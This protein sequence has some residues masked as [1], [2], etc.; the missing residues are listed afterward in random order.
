RTFLTPS[1]LAAA[2]ATGRHP[3]PATSTWTSAPS[4]LAAVSAL[5]VASLRVLLSCSARRS[6]VISTARCVFRPRQ[7]T[8]SN[9]SHLILELVD[10]LA[11][12]LHLDAGLA[13]R[14]LSGLEHFEPRRGIDAVGIRRLLID[15]LL[16][17]LHDVREA[18]IAR[19]V[20]TQVGGHDRRSLQLDRLQA[21]VD[22]ASDHNAVALDHQLR[23]ERALR[24]TG[25]GRQHL[26]G[27]VAVVVDRLL[28]ENDQTR[29]L[30]LDN[31]LEDLGYG[32]RF[33][34]LVGLHQYAAVGTHGEPGANGFGGLRRA[35]RHANDLGGLALFL[36][37]ERLFDRDLV[38]RIHRHLDVREFDA[39]AVALDA[40][41]DVVVDDP[42][43]GHQNFHAVRS[44]DDKRTPPRRLAVARRN[45]A[46]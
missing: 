33:G 12:G 16:L 4:A 19:L 21:A 14:G 38:E 13:A 23:R 45:R 39:A 32:Q 7:S 20:E 42:L 31:G 3:L 35:D 11:D 44:R 24:P 9:Q 18:G 40:D 10:E 30:L 22:L 8:S 26:A 29:L 36:E 41:F 6:V 2:S 25:Q 17:G 34:R 43:Y 1:S 37:P 46:F 27:L 28:A 15:R 5:W